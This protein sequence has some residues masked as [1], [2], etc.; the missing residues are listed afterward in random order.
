M[1]WGILKVVIAGSVIS[2]SSW[3]A[4]QRPALAGF[5]MALPISSLIALIFTQAQFQ[6]AAKSVAF[7]RSIFYSVPLPWSISDG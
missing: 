1:V 6:D 5:V 7:A 2:F 3:L 4:G